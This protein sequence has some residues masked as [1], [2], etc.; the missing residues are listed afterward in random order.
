MVPPDFIV[1]LCSKMKT[2]CP[3]HPVSVAAA[4]GRRGAGQGQEQGRVRV[5]LDLL[6]G[7]RAFCGGNRGE[8]ENQF[9]PPRN[10]QEPP[11]PCLAPAKNP[12]STHPFSRIIFFHRSSVR[13]EAIRG[14]E[15]GGRRGAPAPNRHRARDPRRLRPAI[16]RALSRY[17]AP[18]PAL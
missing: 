7:L 15:R 1:S 13:S 9:P 5:S 3:H 11:S 2:A 8:A 16:L 10:T 6:G 14:G 17:T 4:G 12:F 18:S